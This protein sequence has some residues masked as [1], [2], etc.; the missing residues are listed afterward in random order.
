MKIFNDRL[1]ACRLL[2]GLNAAAIGL[3]LVCGAMSCRRDEPSRRGT[4]EELITL[5]R[6]FLRSG[7]EDGKAILPDENKLTDLNLFIFNG[8]VPEKQIY[9]SGPSLSEHL[10]GKPIEVPLLT[11]CDYGFLACANLG[12][13]LHFSSREEAIAYKYYLAWPD[14]Y[15]PGMVMT[16]VT[17]TRVETDKPV[18]LSL[19]RLMTKV[20]ISID[21][22]RLNKDVR[23]ECRR[24]K[25]GN[26]PRWCRLFSDSRTGG[27][28]DI[29]RDGFTLDSNQCTA[30][31]PHDGTNP[32]GEA[33]LYV[34]ENLQES[35]EAL[36]CY[37]EISLDYQSDTL[38]TL[39]DAWLTYR[40]R[41]GEP[42]AYD[43]RRGEHLHI[44]LRPGGEGLGGDEWRVDRSH[45]EYR[46]GI[47]SYKIL[48][49]D[50][51]EWRIGEEVTV[52]AE[53]FPAAVPYSFREESLYLH[54][55]ERG[56]FSYT[57]S[58]DGRSITLKALKK[59]SSMVDI[60]FGPPINDTHWVL[61]VCEP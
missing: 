26:C 41:L 17:Q 55:V 28:D 14:E 42:G 44:I 39:G 45:L 16:A 27:S 1:K 21:R 43:L 57:L 30:L 24:M 40:F 37:A 4:E 3:I 10:A 48:P 25:I 5:A 19:R 18:V 50:Y 34:L 12:Y 33:S 47:G 38:C 9:L 56:M 29:F 54:A 20:S 8:N 58:G 60:D 13:E 31:N 7:G 51:I 59:G 2:R 46:P 11:G 52:S 49:S 6:L 15:G 22:S 23:M 36:G 61:L 32:S 35:N 53:C